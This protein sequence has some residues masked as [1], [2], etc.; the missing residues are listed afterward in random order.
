MARVHFVKRARKDYPEDGIKKGESYY[1]WQFAYSKKQISKTPPSRSQLTRSEFL[2]TIYEIEDRIAQYSPTDQADLENFRDELVSDLQSLLDETQDKYD[3][4]PEQ[5]RESSD[6]G[7]TLQ[8][9]IDSLEDAISTLE[10]MEVSYE[11][12][13]ETER[14]EG[15]TDE[16]W[17]EYKLD[18]LNS[19]IEEKQAE[20]QDIS[21]PS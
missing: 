17:E 4:M 6:S 20:I 21:L 15:I 9:R 1:W 11:E 8:E 10:S 7:N 18:K 19:W 2:Q 12:P 16:Q 13:D 3:N 14:E 5:L